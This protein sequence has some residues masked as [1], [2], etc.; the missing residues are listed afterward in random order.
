MLEFTKKQKETVVIVADAVDR[1][2]RGFK[3][4]CFN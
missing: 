4:F 1:F 3:E 2:Q